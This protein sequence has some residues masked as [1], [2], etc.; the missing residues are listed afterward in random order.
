[1]VETTKQSG[2]GLTFVA[3]SLSLVMA[4]AASATPIP[5]YGIY[6][7][8]DGVSYG[9]LSLSAVVYFAGAVMALLV[10]GRLSNHLGRRAVSLLAVALAGLA[11]VTLM[12]VH[13]AAPL[14]IGRLFQGLSCGLA[15]TALAAWLVDTA[16]V[17]PSW[18]APAILSCGPMT[19]LTLG[20][21]AS[22]VMVEY[23]P[24]P[25]TLPYLVIL[26]VLVVCALLL[27]RGRE[28]VAGEPGWR[29]SLRPR[30]GLPPSARKAYPVAAC[31]FVC[32]WALGGFY[33]AFGPIMARE[34]LHSSNALAAALVFASL[35]APSVIGASIAGRL[36]PSSAQCL[37]ML[38]F[39]AGLAGVLLSLKLGLL[40]PFLITSVLAGIAQGTTLSGGIQMMVAGTEQEERAGILSVIY[41]TSYTGAAVPTLVA[42]QLSGRLSLLQVASGYGVLALFGCIVVL[43]AAARRRRAT[44]AV[45]ET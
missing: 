31:T 16:P 19:G 23:G 17:S 27:L 34:Q 5:L 12:T 30:F 45:Q 6:Q 36:R 33:Q 10:F 24:S 39:T 22:G 28:T 35:M 4:Y 38:A 18:V 29:A 14:I 44:A 25:R 32:T 9:A 2:D 26:G 1:M 3:A 8:V 41:A 20:G 13:E 21:V 11:S 42:G 43:L 40:V 7:A 37:G 15:S